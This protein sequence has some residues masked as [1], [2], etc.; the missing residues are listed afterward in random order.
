MTRKAE[1]TVRLPGAGIAP[2]SSTWACSKTGLENNGG[3]RYN[4]RRQFER[5]CRHRS[6]TFGKVVTSLRCLSVFVQRSK[7]DEVE[8]RDSFASCI[9]RTAAFRTAQLRF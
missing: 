5:Q 8:L 6:P 7:M 1:V 4:Q 2:S 3:E 9:T